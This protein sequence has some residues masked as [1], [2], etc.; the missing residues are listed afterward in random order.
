MSTRFTF[1][2]GERD[3][4]YG[5]RERCE[6]FASLLDELR[7]DRIDV[8]PATFLFQP[9]H[10]HGGL[11]D[12][13]ILKDMLG[14]ERIPCPTR[15]DW[16]QTDSVVDAFYWIG[17]DEAVRGNE[18]AANWNAP[19]HVRF[20]TSE[21]VKSASL[22]VDANMVDFDQP[23][24]VEWNGNEKEYTLDAPSLRVLCES[25]AKRMD[26]DLSY[27]LSLKIGTDE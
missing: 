1:M 3:T 19:N 9:G 21:N 14:F 17:V 6:K 26:P 11:P 8:Y 20:T 23:L 16:E 18:L 12:R 27:T 4:A 22:L 2:V 15:L 13:D 7:K 5:R 10:G 24:V 25:I